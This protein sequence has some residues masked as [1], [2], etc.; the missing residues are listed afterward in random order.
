VTDKKGIKSPAKATFDYKNL[1]E[2]IGWRFT[3]PLPIWLRP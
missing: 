3:R 2:W 1:S